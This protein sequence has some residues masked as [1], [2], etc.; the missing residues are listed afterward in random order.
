MEE[1]GGTVTDFYGNPL[2]F[3]CGRTLKNNVG[4]IATNGKFHSK[5]LNAATQV[6]GSKP[7]ISL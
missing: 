3:G 1:A 2:D 5:V 7:K 6:V 4:V